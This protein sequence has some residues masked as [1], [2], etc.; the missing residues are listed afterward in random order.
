[1]HQI[2]LFQSTSH[3]GRKGPQSE[4]PMKVLTDALKRGISMAILHCV[5]LWWLAISLDT[6]WR[7]SE[8]SWVVVSQHLPAIFGSQPSFSV[9]LDFD[10]RFSINKSAVAEKNMKN[11]KCKI[12]T[13]AWNPIPRVSIALYGHPMP[14]AYT[15]IPLKQM[16]KISLFINFFSIILYPSS[17]FPCELSSCSSFLPPF[18]LPYPLVHSFSVYIQK[19]A[20]HPW[21]S[22]KQEISSRGSLFKKK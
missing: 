22:T 8:S 9:S 1:M 13:T 12:I 2:Y 18:C 4:F 20:G 7:F 19:E 10:R 6:L 17:S 15:Q 14:V 5:C 21:V 3:L 11:D 16:D